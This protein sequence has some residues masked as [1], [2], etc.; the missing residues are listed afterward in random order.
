VDGRLGEKFQ[1][2]KKDTKVEKER[3]R[4]KER[5][6]P[7]F[8]RTE[9]LAHYIQENAGNVKK[10]EIFS[11]APGKP[12]KLSLFDSFLN[13]DRGNNKNIFERRL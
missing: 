5:N 13:N 3:E 6:L 1:F 8:M 11:P 7:P 10:N 2:S 4:E 9:K 12:S